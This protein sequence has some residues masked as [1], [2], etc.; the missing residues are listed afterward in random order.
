M[1][2]V[3]GGA[4]QGKLS[5]AKEHL[6]KTDKNLMENKKAEKCDWIDGETCDREAIY[7]C[8]GIYHFHRYVGNFL[9]PETS[10]D[11][12]FSGKTA[13]DLDTDLVED[14]DTDFVGDFAKNL[15]EKNPNIIVVTDEIGY[16]IVPLDYGERVYREQ[17]GRVCTALAKES[18][19]VYRVICGI[20]NRIK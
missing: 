6:W 4:Y 10:L 12:K 19:E 5:W 18:E 20:G 11:S 3:I 2:M 17:V 14:L 9:D 13:E 1:K 7:Y 15:L 8:T 16:G